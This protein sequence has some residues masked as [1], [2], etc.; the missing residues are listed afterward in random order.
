MKTIDRL[1]KVDWKVIEDH[2]LGLVS[3]A[4]L[5]FTIQSGSQL[6]LTKGQPTEPIT[7]AQR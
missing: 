6:F 1:L 5:L 4:S 3:V 7:E 2:I